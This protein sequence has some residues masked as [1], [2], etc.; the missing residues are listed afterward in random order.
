MNQKQLNLINEKR[1]TTIYNKQIYQSK[2]AKV[3]NRRA[4]PRAFK[5]RD[6]VLKKISLASR[7]DQNK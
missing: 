4:R 5:E 7:E 3:C 2:M 6:L 1:L